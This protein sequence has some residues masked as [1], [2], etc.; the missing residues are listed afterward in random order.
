M[1]IKFLRSFH[2]LLGFFLS[3]LF[4]LWFASGI[5]MIYHSFPRASQE[6]RLKNLAVLP[7]SLPDVRHLGQ[8]LPD[9]ARIQSLLLEMQGGAPVLALRGKGVPEK[10]YAGTLTPVPPYDESRLGA[11]VA[12]WC[13]A[14]VLRIDTLYQPD[15]WI[16]FGR[17]RGSF[18]VYKYT[19]D[20]AARHELYVAPK[21]GRVLQL[22]DR[23]ERFWA[24]LGAIPHWVYFTILRQNQPLWINFVKWAAGIGAL[25]CLAGWILSL[26]ITWRTRKLVPY[27]KRWYRWHHLLGLVFGIFA[28]TFA[29]SGMMSLTDIPDWMKRAP[30]EKRES[31]PPFRG[32]M[33]GGTPIRPEAYTLDYR[34]AVAAVPGTKRVEWSAWNGHPYYRLTADGKNC[35]IDASDSLA[36]RPFRITEAMVRHEMEKQYG[37]SLA[38][39]LTLL[40]DFDDDY[41]S[42]KRD[43]ES[44]P[45]YRVT[46]DDDMHTRHYYNPQTLRSWRVDD[47]SRLRHLLYRGLHCLDFKFLTDRPWLWNLAMYTFMLGGTALSVTGIV[48]SYKWI[49]RK[50]KHLLSIHKTT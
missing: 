1:I 48:L 8:S 20:D 3:I 39:H 49:A 27:R 36:V 30:K 29:F 16:P 15:Q 26:W 22:T 38:W 35:L 43:A 7:D 12:E 41:F 25:M 19:F 45:V 44:L 5:V 13:P 46:V 21:E 31:R 47:D 37:D 50:I 23:Q 14:P 17:P 32:M 9:T 2:K 6:K 4:L 33:G 28:A 11:V 10:L 34:K 42:R 40:Q 18:P 24:W